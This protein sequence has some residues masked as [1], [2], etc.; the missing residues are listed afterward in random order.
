MSG[1]TAR[2]RTA[3]PRA[4]KELG[5][6]NRRN[7]RRACSMLWGYRVLWVFGFLFA[8]A[9]GAG[10]QALRNNANFNSGNSRSGPSFPN[11]PLSSINWN[12]VLTIAGIVLG[13]V[14]LLAV[15]GAIV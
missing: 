6:N 3:R 4:R 11:I 9:G 12:L 13:V 5:V 10:G 1:A 8:L 2:R 14:L 15:V 7:L